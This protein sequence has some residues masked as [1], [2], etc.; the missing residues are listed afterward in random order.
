[1]Q[2]RQM[3]RSF[4]LVVLI[5]AAAAPAWAGPAAD[6]RL[7]KL[8]WMAGS[9]A[10]DSAGT[11]SEEHW[12]AARGGLMAGMNRLVSGGRARSFEF[13]RIQAAGDSIAYVASPNNR[14]PTVF[15]LK[16]QGEKRVVFENPT[17]DFPQRL[18]YWLGSDGRLFARVEGMMN[19]K[20]AT[21]DFVWTK[22]SL[23]P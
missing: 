23:A 21:E 22:G 7:E 18:I 16:E 10:R 11:R 6:A 13:L 17:H 20:S 8:S 19:G 15:P 9:W 5:T 1:M 2:T 3:A 12:M 14:P 4:V